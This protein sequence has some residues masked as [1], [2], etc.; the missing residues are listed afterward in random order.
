MS[1]SNTN[2]ARKLSLYCPD[3]NKEVFNFLLTS[4]MTWDDMIVSIQAALQCQGKEVWPLD[5]NGEPFYDTDAVFNFA[6]IQDGEKLFVKL[7]EGFRITA[8]PDL[9]VVL[10]LEEEDPDALP[11][12]LKVSHHNVLEGHSTHS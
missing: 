8:L 9:E 11:K 1:S 4:S 10:Y 3:L 6:S 2:K 12:S 7:R 5:I